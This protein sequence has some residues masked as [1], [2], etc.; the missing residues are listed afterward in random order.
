ME[1]MKEQTEAMKEK[2]EEAM[3]AVRV[4]EAADKIRKEEEIAEALERAESNA[5]KINPIA[6]TEA[7]SDD[8]EDV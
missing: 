3:A 2:M 8:A 5:A 1:Q 7:E 4:A 6:E